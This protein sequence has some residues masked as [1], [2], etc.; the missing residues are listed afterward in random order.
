MTNAQKIVELY[1]YQD[2]GGGFLELKTE[3]WVRH[4]LISGRVERIGENKVRLCNRPTGIAKANPRLPSERP[5]GEPSVHMPLW[6]SIPE[7]GR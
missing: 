7:I 5:W 4:R 1:D 3:A 6:A 2:A